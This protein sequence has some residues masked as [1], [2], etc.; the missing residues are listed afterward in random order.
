VQLPFLVVH[1]ALVWKVVLVVFVASCVG[2]FLAI[3]YVLVRAA[4]RSAMRDLDTTDEGVIRGTLRDGL[5]STLYVASTYGMP[6]QPSFHAGDLVIET[7]DGNVAL[8]GDIR[9]AA[10][11]RV[12]A[13]RRHLP[14]ST[15]SELAKLHG[16]S[17]DSTITTAVLHQV[18]PGDAVIAKAR[19]SAKR[20]T[21]RPAIARTRRGE[22]YAARS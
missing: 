4:N 12:A 18:H 3:R 22:C 5:A 1:A 16:D 15:P 19:S 13:R 9:V 20:V 21:R 8:E 2:A 17:A 11:S 10:G 7:A 6:K 14:E